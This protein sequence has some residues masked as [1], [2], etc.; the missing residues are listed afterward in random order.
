[1]N[2][3][4]VT[5]VLY[6]IFAVGAL[7]LIALAVMESAANA[8][9]YTFVREA[10]RPGRLVEFASMSAVIAIALLLRQ[11]RDELHKKA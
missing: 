5:S 6:R 10:Y 1:M 9:R 8:F 3:N 2:Y 11:I 7:V 4:K